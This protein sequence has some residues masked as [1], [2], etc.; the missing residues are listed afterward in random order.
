MA[1]SLPASTSAA[2]HGSAASAESSSAATAAGSSAAEP[3]FFP[4]PGVF[5]DDTQVTLHCDTPGAVIHYTFDGSQPL[6]GSPVYTGPIQVKGT[7]LTIKAFATAP[8]KKDSA[9][10]TGTYRIRE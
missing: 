4:K 7:A 1:S 3:A 10:V 8:G 6:A 2:G 9:V 5:D